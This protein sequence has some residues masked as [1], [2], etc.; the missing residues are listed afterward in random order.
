MDSSA[1]GSSPALPRALPALAKLLGAEYRRAADR[2]GGG[3]GEVVHAGEAARIG[4]SCPRCV[5]NALQQEQCALLPTHAQR[6]Y[7]RW[8]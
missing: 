8:E 6:A 2:G 5:F 3:V 1:T 4:A 7:A